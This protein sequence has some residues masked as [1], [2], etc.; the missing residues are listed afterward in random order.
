M[1]QLDKEVT[2]FTFIDDYDKTDVFEA[3]ITLAELR[4]FTE[5]LA[6]DL[7]SQLK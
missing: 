3:N 2:G 4:Q 5:N 7:L 1:Q 6:S